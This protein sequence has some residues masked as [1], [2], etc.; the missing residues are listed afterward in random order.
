LLICLAAAAP[1]SAEWTIA[2]FIGGAHTQATSLRL[3]Q[4][5]HA[6]D[7]T[8]SPIH[9]R[10]ESMRPPLYYA[11]RFGFF[12]QSGWFGIEGE[13][14]HLKVH[15]DVTRPTQA[16]GTFGGQPLEGSIPVASLIEEF[17]IS[18]GVNLVLV[19]AVVRR[20]YDIDPSGVPRWTLVGRFG[21]GTSRPHPESTIAGQRFEGYQW[22]SPSAQV[23]GGVEMHVKGPVFLVGEYKLTR[24]VQEVTIADGT[25]RTPLTSHHLVVGAA[26]RLGPSRRAP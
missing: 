25:A 21:F 13:L 23:T 3:V 6:T 7:L 2:G 16:S 26:L 8:L 24:T 11:Y 14:I 22:G 19:N 18:H 9:Y 12:P 5:L 10:S 20:G 17:S 15:A 1:A 4:P